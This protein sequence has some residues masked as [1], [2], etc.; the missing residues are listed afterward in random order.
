MI[1]ITKYKKFV[2]KFKGM[3]PSNKNENMHIGITKSTFPRKTVTQKEGLRCKTS[4]AIQY[5]VWPPS[6]V[7]T[8]IM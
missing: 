1:N 6:E 7:T 4:H 2:F 8:T 3:T 5:S